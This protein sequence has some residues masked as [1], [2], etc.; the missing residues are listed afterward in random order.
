MGHK[1]FGQINRGICLGR[2]TVSVEVISMKDKTIWM[3]FA[4]SGESPWVGYY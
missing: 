1:K 2:L 3:G 4:I